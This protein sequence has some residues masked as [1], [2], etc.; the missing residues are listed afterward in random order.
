[1]SSDSSIEVIAVTETLAASHWLISGGVAKVWNF[2]KP[3]SESLVI[4]IPGNEIS[5]YV[6]RVFGDIQDDFSDSRQFVYFKN[7]WDLI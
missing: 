4:E 2:L 7:P 6:N 1:M 5:E 3:W